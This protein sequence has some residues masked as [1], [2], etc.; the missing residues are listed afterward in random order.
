MKIRLLQWNIW[1]QE[2]IENIEKVIRKLSPDIICLQEMTIN[3]TNNDY[4]NT[5]DFLSKKLGL[6]SSFGK[7][8][9][10]PDKSIIGNAILS[11]FPIINEEIIS[12]NNNSSN[13]EDYS[14]QGRVCIVVDINLPD[15]KKV[16]ISTAHLSYIHKFK[17]SK[18]KIEE[19]DRLIRIFESQDKN[20]IF[21]GDLNLPPETKSIK[22]ICSILDSCGPSFKE[23]SWTTKPFSYQ[24]FEEKN[25]NW[26]LDYVFATKDIKILSSEIISTKYSDHLPIL[27]EIE[28]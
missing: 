2:K 7:A 16:K 12:V 19:V 3:E 6:N 10:F 5:V 18:S 9:E 22:K 28:I 21:A 25:L 11:K 23:N 27:V 1:Y 24:G 14:E 13:S 4:K 26:R 20:F 17:E 15:D 8:H